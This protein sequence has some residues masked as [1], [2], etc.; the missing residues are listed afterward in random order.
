MEAKE[1]PIGGGITPACAGNRLLAVN[2]QVDVWDHPRLRGEQVM[3]ALTEFSRQ[4]SP[5][6]ARGTEISL[7]VSICF[8][9][10]TPACAG[11]S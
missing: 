9:G 7:Q 4:G 6:L 8:N 10:I 1:K 11:N 5:P 3:D 2:Q